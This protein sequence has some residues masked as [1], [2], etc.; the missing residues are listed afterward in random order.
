MYKGIISLLFMYA[1]TYFRMQDNLKYDEQNF[2]QMLV[3]H[4]THVPELLN[5][6]SH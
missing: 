5:V 6:N 4:Y 1:K 2:N 3:Q